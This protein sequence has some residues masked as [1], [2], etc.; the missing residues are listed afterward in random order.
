MHNVAEKIAST[1]NTQIMLCERGTSF[2]YN[3]LVNDFRGL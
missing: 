1:G 2:G 3:T